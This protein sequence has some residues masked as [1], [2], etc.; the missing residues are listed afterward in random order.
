MPRKRKTRHCTSCNRPT[1]SVTRYC[2]DCRP[3]NAVP[4]IHRVGGGI[5]F[6]GWTFSH[7]QAIHLANA[8]IDTLE[9]PAP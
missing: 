1:K 9:E 7:D 4:R 8:I 6:A 2:H 3:A 5:S